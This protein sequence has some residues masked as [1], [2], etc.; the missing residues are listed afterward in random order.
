MFVNSLFNS[1]VC[2]ST[3]CLLPPAY[4]R[5]CVYYVYYVYYV[6]YVFYVICRIC[7][8]HCQPISR[9]FLRL[10]TLSPPC[11]TYTVHPGVRRERGG[12]HRGRRQSREVLRGIRSSGR[13]LKHRLQRIHRYVCM[14]VCMY[15]CMFVCMYVCIC[16]YICMY[17]Y[18]CMY[19][20][21]LTEN[22][23]V[24]TG[25]YIIS[26]LPSLSKIF[27]FIIFINPF[28]LHY[29]YQNLTYLNI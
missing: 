12:H 5:S 18:V 10:T 20:C 2:V 24:S 17:M 1:H 13:I 23:N 6:F 22:C 19:G 4:L 27:I 26:L 16:M 21:L 25:M 28:H 15:I 9:L 3:S 8:L 29:L 7:F 11:T 14:Y